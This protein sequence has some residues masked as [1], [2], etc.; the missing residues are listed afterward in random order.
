MGAVVIKYVYDAWGNHEV[1]ILDGTPEDKQA[2]HIGNLNPIR[3]R[4][5]Y[6]D[7]ETGL[8]FLK[9]RYYDPQICRFITI[10]DIQY[11]DPEHINGLNL[12]AYCGDNPVMGYDPNGTWDWKKFWGWL[13]IAV[14]L[15]ATV[16]I[17][18][19][20]TVASFGAFTPLAGFALAVVGGAA[21][22]F[23]GGVVGNISSQVQQVCWDNVDLGKTWMAGGIGAI[24]GAITGALSFGVGEIAKGIGQVIG[25]S[26]SKVS[27]SGLPVWKLVNS[28]TLAAAFG[29]VS[30]LFGAAMAT[31]FGDYIGSDLLGKTNDMKDTTGNIILDW[32][33]QFGRWFYKS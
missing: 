2:T 25:F 26:L 14:A 6:Y 16:V 3:Y 15:V 12:Y 9:T 17:G 18:V 31:Y 32:I 13:G 22:G 19:I 21:L 5:Y 24:G 23:A 30:S 4:G 1:K 8:Y 10:D 11:L 27:I 20:A 28:K 7:V 29:K 33:L